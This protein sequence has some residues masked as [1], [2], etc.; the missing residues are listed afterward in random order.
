MKFKT[1]LNNIKAI[2]HIID[3]ALAKRMKI[4]KK[5]SCTEAAVT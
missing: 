5:K 2:K 1:K 3:L 4:Y